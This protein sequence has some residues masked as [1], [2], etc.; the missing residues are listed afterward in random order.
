[1]LSFTEIKLNGRNARDCVVKAMRILLC[2]YI[3]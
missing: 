2:K 1:M 3:I